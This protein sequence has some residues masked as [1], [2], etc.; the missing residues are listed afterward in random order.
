[1]TT[2]RR[3]LISYIAPGAPATR[4][5]AS[6]REP[7]LRPEIGFT[8]NWYR[9]ALGIDFGERFHT[10]PTYRCEA[11]IAMRDELRRRFPGTGIG[12]L[13]RPEPLDLLTGTYGACSVAAI[14]G[15]PIRFA[16]DNWP[17]C[18]HRYLED[19]QVDA[20]LPPDLGANAFFQD[21]MRQ[22][23]RIADREGRVE[24][25]LNWQ[26]TLNNAYRLRGAQLFYDML[27]APDRA[28]H[29]LD[30]VCTTMMDGARRLH[31]R[32]RRTGAI[33]DFFTVSNCLVN[34][35]SPSQYRD[36]LLPFDRKIAEAFGCLGIHNC[37]W[38]ADPYLDHYAQAPNLAYID[39]GIDSDLPRARALFPNARRA[40]M[41]T[42]MDLADKPPETLRADLARIARD[43]APCD[44]VAADIE[45]GTPDER[46][47]ALLELCE[48]LSR[49]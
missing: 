45:A 11:V 13:D 2:L 34:M 21:L 7:R 43:Y 27:E 47:W 33:V 19:E 40:I 15:I 48:E 41:Y 46:V 9:A 49:P 32:Q 8:P 29:L 31:A 22:V 35:V 4:R 25:F 26:G 42:P 37:A 17:N 14:Y 18:E 10:D 12:G 44:L 38:T 30:C 39:M 16:S 24:G 1:M 23:D 36:L 28:R 6:G 20:L 5:P 3:Q